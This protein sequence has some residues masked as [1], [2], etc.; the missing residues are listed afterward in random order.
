MSKS[1]KFNLLTKHLLLDNVLVEAV[2]PAVEEG[3]VRNPQQYGDKP[4]IGIVLSVGPGR[5]TEQG[6]KL[7]MT[8]FTG[9]VVLFN[10]YLATKFRLDGNDYYVV[11]EDD[12]VA[13]GNED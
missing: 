6:V 9:M 13:Y 7:P 1:V 3:I 2:E 8:V 11:R 12:I 4:E 5:V 10:K